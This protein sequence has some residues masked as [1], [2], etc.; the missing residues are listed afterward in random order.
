MPSV[1]VGVP[2][3]DRVI[4]SKC[5]EALGNAVENAKAAGLDRVVHRYVGGYDVAR[6]RNMMARAAVEEKVDY[7]WMVDSDVVVPP[8]ALSTLISD[9]VDL[10]MGWYVRGSSDDGTTCAIRAGSMG[11]MDS[12][13]ADELA[14]AGL[15]PVKGNGMGCALVRTSVFGR[16][17]RPWFKFVENPDGSALSEDY[18]FCQHCAQAGVQPH[19][20][21]RV[22]CGHIHERILEAM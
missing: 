6:A 22:G 21:G 9:G 1:M 14:G 8:D 13:K 18:W 3:F 12:L 16:V 19:V 11:F 10:A 7:L 5:S 17:A 15:V 2:T 20:D 4:K